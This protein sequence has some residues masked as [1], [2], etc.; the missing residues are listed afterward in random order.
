MMLPRRLA[1]TQS[2]LAAALALGCCLPAARAQ[3]TASR[4]QEAGLALVQGNAQ[5]AIALFGEALKEPNLSNERRATLHNDRGIA[6]WRASQPK[7]AIE[8]FN[9]SVAL[10]PESAAAYNNRGNVLLALDLTA[11]AI[12]DFDRALV[13]TPGY[14]AAYNNR[15]TAHLQAGRLDLAALD[16][17]RAIELQPQSP[18]P[19]M[20]RGRA[21]LAQSRPYSA[22]RDF[23][24]AI[25]LDAKD[26]AAFRYRARAYLD[27][28]H[29]NE[30][31]EDFNRAITLEPASAA[32]YMARGRAH[33]SLKNTQAALKDLGKAI[34]LD[35]KL[36]P[37]YGYRGLARAKLS[38]YDEALADFAKAVELDPRFAPAYVHRAS[39]YRLMDQPETGLRDIERALK[40]EPAHAEGFR[41]RA[42]LHEALGRKDEAIADYRQ[43][44]ALDFGQR[45]S[46]EALERL[47][48]EASIE[49][50]ELVGNGQGGWRVFKRANGTYLA[51]NGTYPRLLIS[52]EMAGPG[53]PRVMG[54]EE[55]KGAFK[56]I[57]VLRYD[58]GAA[59]GRGAAGAHVELAAV[60]DTGSARIVTIEPDRLG[61]KSS[62]W[63]WED[64]KLTVAGL[65]GLTNEFRLRDQAKMKP[66]AASPDDDEDE[67]KARKSAGAGGPDWAPWNEGRPQQRRSERA[68]QDRAPSRKPKTLFD[69][70]FN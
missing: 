12:K 41:V 61:D 8:E 69:L 21:R 53:E 24:R 44:L 45:E 19:I 4:A 43:A 6:F 62:K 46:A 1:V 59:D 38:Q 63:T 13:L 16:F 60:V 22:L 14:V 57:G 34:E 58:A 23:S 32:L 10:L 66:V 26:A 18:A 35:A 70:L 54:W 36:A 64:G 20:G 65:D 49:A 2:A 55:Q 5:Q 40:L 52:L 68:S 47:T 48:G 30:A 50:Q 39:T 28:D 37:A 67:R 42:E 51:N 27:I 17:S 29:A 11:E 33:L 25:G 56:G 31:I 9:R 3:T 7:A 15:G